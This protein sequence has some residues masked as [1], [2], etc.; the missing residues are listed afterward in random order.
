MLLS[1]DEDGEIS[2]WQLKGQ[3][4]KSLPKHN[5]EVTSVA[6]SSDSEF[7]VTAD[8]GGEGRLWRISDS[9]EPIRKI[10]H[11]AAIKKILFSP[12]N[13]LIATASSDNTIKLWKTLDGTLLITLKGHQAEVTAID[14]LS[15]TGQLLLASAS[16]DNTVILW[17]IS[18]LGEIEKLI[19]QGCMWI[20]DYLK[21]RTEPRILKEECS[22]MDN[23]S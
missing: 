12:D 7:L 17:D 8:Q 1:A 2:L 14:F 3:L 18:E 10:G 21:D 11:T 13:Q 22:K 19:K 4:L 9:N 20:K 23:E 5:R 15:K 6:F 16:E